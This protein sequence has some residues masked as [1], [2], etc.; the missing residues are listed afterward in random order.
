MHPDVLLKVF[1]ELRARASEYI[2]T[3]YFT[4]DPIFNAA[5]QQLLA[6]TRTGPVFRDPCFEPIRRYVQTSAHAQEL[7]EIAGLT[8]LLEQHR[9]QAIGLLKCFGPIREQSL[10]EHQVT[11]IH[12]ALRERKPI[13]V[14]TGTGSGKSFCFQIPIVLSLLSEAFGAQGRARWDGATAQSAAWWHDK[15]PKFRLARASSNRTPAMRCLIMYPLNALVQDQV[16]GLRSI[17]NSD[18]AERLYDGA[19]GNDRIFFGQYNGATPGKGSVDGYPSLK[20]CAKELWR[21]ESTAKSIVAGSDASVQKVGGSELLTRWDMQ[22]TPP[23]FLITNYTMLSIMLLREREQG[24]FDRTREWLDESKENRFY[25]VVDELHSYRGTGGTEISYIIRSLLDRL[26]LTPDDPQL[27]IIATSASLPSDYGEKFLAEFFGTDPDKNPF[28]MISGPE[29]PLSQPSV[30]WVRS[31][32]GELS[33]LATNAATEAQVEHILRV[34][35]DKAGHVGQPLSPQILERLAL[36]DPLVLASKQAIEEHEER[37]KLTSF[38]LQVEDIAR[39]LFKGSQ[40]AA[41]GYLKLI[42]GD[43][44]CTRDLKAKTRMHL[45]VRNLDGIRR[46]MD[47]R[48]SDLGAP[49]LYDAATP[50]CVKTGA[51]NLDSYYCQECGEIYYFGY[52]G[53]AATRNAA[54]QDV[55]VTNDDSLDTSKRSHGVLLHFPRPGIEYTHTDW[56]ARFFNGFTGHMAPLDNDRYA[57]CHVRHVPFAAGRYQLPRACPQ[58]DADWSSRPIIKSPIRSMGT[59]YNKF[60]QVIVEQLV[61][62][63]RQAS[64]EAKSSKLVLFSDSRREAALLSADLELNHYRD[65]VRALTEQH[66]D[67]AVTVDPDLTSFIAQLE[68]CKENGRWVELN[69]H[70]YRLKNPQGSRSLKDYFRGELGPYDTEASAEAEFL[71]RSTQLPLA[72]LFGSESSITSKVCIDLVSRGMNPGG[73]RTCYDQ[74]WQSAFALPP[75]SG[76]PDEVKA[77]RRVRD[78]FISLLGNEVR[79]VVTGSMGRDFESLGYGWLTF[80]RFHF[81]ARHLDAKVISLLDCVLRFLVKHY[82]TRNRQAEGFSNQLVGYFLEWLKANR[83]GLWSDLSDA[84]TSDTVRTLLMN[85]GAIDAAF[86]VQREGLFFHPHGETFWRCDKCRSVHLFEAD[87]RC[88]RVKYNPKRAKSACNGTLQRRPIAELAAEENYYRS[89]AKLG[90]HQYP[91]RTEE[92]IGH[93]DKLEQRKRQLAFQGKFSST[94]DQRTLTLQEFEKYYGIDALS[95]TTTMEA[96]V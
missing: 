10:F 74:T 31:C 57:A 93:T 91:L 40:E 79:E 23:D 95:V 33:T 64:P 56:E 43:W 63:L 13:V 45:F 39:L 48:Q 94:P 72:R 44:H 87:G 55:Y 51:L 41:V 71:L 18:A 7:L 1:D 80:N 96:G 22:Q 38:P 54:A 62:T 11:S 36:H 75:T 2:N 47:T 52:N 53:I 24:I 16:D 76:S 14:T 34:L 42:T 70:P 90:R 68:S 21:I 83:Y 28:A 50:V 78:G 27:Q 88:R 58:C 65:T 89:L 30:E 59:G 29:M 6:D 77:R 69:E 15:T 12:T 35:A 86:R 46:A 60:S 26:N 49:I 19:L 4:N 67:A 5:R 3:A 17:L 85:V 92:L 66:L 25:L 61:G 81:A 82:K 37:A 32:Q 9:D 84:E 8:H 73:L 20:E